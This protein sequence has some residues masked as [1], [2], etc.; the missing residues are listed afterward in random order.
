ML[1]HTADTFSMINIKERV[2]ELFYMLEKALKVKLE[3]Q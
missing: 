2:R 1:W 3:T